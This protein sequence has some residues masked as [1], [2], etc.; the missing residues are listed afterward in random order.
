M[1]QSNEIKLNLQM[2]N[3][4]PY[5]ILAHASIGQIIV[6]FQNI[7]GCQAK[8]V[9]EEKLYAIIMPEIQILLDEYNEML[10]SN[11]Y[12]EMQV[13]YYNLLIDLPKGVSINQKEHSKIKMN[14]VKIG[15]LIQAT[16]QRLEFI[17]TRPTPTIY[18]YNEN[19]LK[20]FN[21][22]QNDSKLFLDSIINFE[23]VFVN[24]IRTCYK[25]RT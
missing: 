7:M 22:L 8:N 1:E 6:C 17:I 15:S 4:K 11:S 12:E 23:H 18:Q 16:K 21:K 3:Y 9:Y 5:F 13:K 20:E 10:S 19:L 2:V 24:A 25:Y 14:N